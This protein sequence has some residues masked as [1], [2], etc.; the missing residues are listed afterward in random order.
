MISAIFKLYNITIITQNFIRKSREFKGERGGRS[1]LSLYTYN[2]IVYLKCKT[3]IFY[4][5]KFTQCYDGRG[6]KNGDDFHIIRWK[7]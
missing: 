5:R 2:I 1:P 6:F 7:R 3:N 4:K